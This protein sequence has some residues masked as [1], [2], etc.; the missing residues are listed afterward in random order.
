MIQPGT[1]TTVEVTASTPE[2]NLF[3]G[4]TQTIVMANKSILILN[5]PG[6]A[7]LSDFD[8]NTYGDEMTLANI[9]NKCGALC[10]QLGLD[11]DFR[12]TDEENEMFRFIARD[13]EDYD[14]LIINPIGYARAATVNFEMFR[15]A[16]ML[17]AHLKKPVIEVHITNIFLPGANITRPLQVP[18]G[19]MGFISGLGMQSYLLAIKAINQQISKEAK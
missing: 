15:N 9:E 14:G 1:G 19:N 13:S 6:L 8:G 12:Q 17:I 2:V 5:G 4:I 3:Q 10:D 11:V 7:D 18:E 16:I